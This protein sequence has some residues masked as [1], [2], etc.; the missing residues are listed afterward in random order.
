M[1]IAAA[2]LGWVALPTAGGCSSKDSSRESA[3]PAVSPGSGPSESKRAD[4]AP[5]PV[6][7]L[8]PMG[9]PGL[10][11]YAYS[12]GKG[13]RAF[14]QALAVHRDSDP[15]DWPAIAEHCRTTLEADPGHLEAHWYLGLALARRGLYEQVTE[16]LATAVAGD[17]MRWGE[18]SLA[19]KALA[20]FYKSPSG[21]QFQDLVARYRQRFR[22]RIASGALLVGRRGTPWYPER[23]G[24]GSLNHRSEIYVYSPDDQHYIRLS[25]SNGSLVGF[26]VAPGGTELA[27]VS[28]RAIFTPPAARAS[29]SEDRSGGPEDHPGPG[30]YIRTATIGTIDLE[31]ARMSERDIDLSGV[32]ELWLTYR[33]SPGKLLAR[34]RSPRSPEPNAPVRTLRTYR[35]DVTRGRAELLTV[36]S[37]DP[38]SAGESPD[39]DNDRASGA[40]TSP[41][42]SGADGAA[43]SDPDAGPLRGD[44]LHVAY[45]RVE[46]LRLPI[47]GVLADWDDSGAAGAFR[48]EHTRTTVTL[49]DG[50]L[51][52]GHTMNWSPART[53]L[54]FAGLPQP[55][56]TECERNAIT[57]TTTLYVAEAATGAYRQVAAAVGLQAPVW[58]DDRRLAFIDTSGRY[59]AVHILDVES[60]EPAAILKTTG[61]LGTRY[62][63]GVPFA[64]PGCDPP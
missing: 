21:R 25:R 53:R 18:R 42:E 7:P 51:A 35:L 31:R 13:R 20:S 5:V 62:V 64:I 54:A 57:T 16:H 40:F 50:G 56:E 26:L 11:D 59:S 33:R 30:A 41:G 63:P 27:Y 24:K 39:A 15:K 37:A 43:A 32:A 36:E 49:A 46:N 48:L 61:G 8:R 4:S 28:Y 45:D 44:V 22:E 3:G 10:R 60:G 19:L 14:L 52:L 55:S 29:V 9:R 17:F 23:P 12:V 1:A 58:L 38:R 2:A 34:V 47:D 6:L